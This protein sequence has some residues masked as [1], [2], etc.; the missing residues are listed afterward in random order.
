MRC[1]GHSWVI[2]SYHMQ[3]K[4]WQERRDVAAAAA[5][6]DQRP[7]TTTPTTGRNL[8]KALGVKGLEVRVAAAS[9]IAVASL[10]RRQLHQQQL[11]VDSDAGSMFEDVDDGDD[12]DEDR[13]LD[14]LCCTTEDDED[15]DELT[16]VDT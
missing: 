13:D 7:V 12:A 9:D 4:Q 6:V 14:E 5:T 1:P 2:F 15:E 10:T 11:N 16:E 8:V 3:I